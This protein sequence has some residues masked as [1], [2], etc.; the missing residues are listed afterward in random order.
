MLEVTMERDKDSTGSG[1]SGR[2][3]SEEGEGRGK[4]RPGEAPLSPRTSG[5]CC[6]HAAGGHTYLMILISPLHV[7]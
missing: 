3:A 6:I 5:K 7:S 2:G 1:D 4:Q